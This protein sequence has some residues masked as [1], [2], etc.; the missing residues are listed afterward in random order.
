MSDTIRKDKYGVK[1]KETLHKKKAPHTCR[2][3][4]CL[5]KQRS[6]DKIAEKEMKEEIKKDSYCYD[7]EIVWDKQ[8]EFCNDYCCTVKD[9]EI[10]NKYVINNGTNSRNNR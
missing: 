1:R 5:G 8:G 9:E 3:E 2:C 6:L 4:Y 10:V 7:D